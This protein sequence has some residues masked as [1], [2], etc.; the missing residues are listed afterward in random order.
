MNARVTNYDGSITADPQQLA[1]PQSV[2]ELQAILRDT[3]RF[4]SPVRAMGSYHSLTPCASS[5]GTMID[6]SGLR[7]IVAIDPKSMTITARA[8]LQWIDAATALRKQNLQFITNIEIGNMTIGSAACCHSKDALDGT[9][10]GQA[11]SY[12]T[13]MKWVTPSGELAE[14]SEQSD[15]ATLR[16]MRSS[17]GL[18]GVI[19]EATFRV[20]PLEAIR[21]TYLPRPVSELSEEE[22]AEIIS[23]SPGLVCWTVG[24]TAVFQTRTHAKKPSWTGS[25]FAAIRRHAWSHSAARIGRLVDLHVPAGTLKDFAHEAAFAALRTTY[26]ALHAVGGCAIMNPDKTVD[27]RSTPASCKYVFT[28]W[29]FPRATWLAALRDY[30]QFADEH[31]RKYAFRC[32]LPLGSYYV[33]RDTNGILSYSHDG[34]MFSVDPIHACSDGA[35]WGRFLQEFNEFCYE[36]GG[37]PLL[38]Q[39]PSV[40]KRHVAAAYGE[41]WIEFSEW[42]RAS[43]PA[44]R[45]LSP[46]FAELLA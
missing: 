14:A 8:G 39:T 43:D 16:M 3:N 5:S 41:R 30:L 23:R 19:Y 33:R 22:V 25:T 44:G 29:A 9:E 15:P 28:F 24:H 18:A 4:P 35:A 20:K 32:N 7:E 13:R 37:V 17:Y 11:S 46:F 31:F 45:M 26:R 42:V 27:Y 12:V 21:F 40:A 1:R 36:R 34:D 10:F 6:M 2:A 38:N